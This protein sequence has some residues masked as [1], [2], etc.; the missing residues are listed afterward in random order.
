[1]AMMGSS[2]VYF[3]NRYQV[4]LHKLVKILGKYAIKTVYAY[5]GLMQNNRTK[6]A[7][8]RLWKANFESFTQCGALHEELISS[9]GRHHVECNQNDRLWGLVCQR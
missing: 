2:D 3:T 8:N 6:L 1:M 4:I 5:R 7:W 9:K